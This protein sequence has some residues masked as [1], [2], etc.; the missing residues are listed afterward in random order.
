MK[1]PI[2][3]QDISALT[4]EQCIEFMQRLGAQ[5]ILVF[6]Q[7]DTGQTGFFYGNLCEQDIAFILAEMSNELCARMEEEKEEE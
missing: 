6:A 5:K 4:P 1:S 3:I 7:K 2:Q